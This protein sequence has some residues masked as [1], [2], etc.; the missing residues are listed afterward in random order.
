MLEPRLQA[1][2]YCSSRFQARAADELE[3][4]QEGSAI[5]EMLA[6]YSLMRI[7]FGRASAATQP[8]NPMI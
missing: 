4:V 2:A 1:P 3:Q 6:D 8:A 7:R 5:T